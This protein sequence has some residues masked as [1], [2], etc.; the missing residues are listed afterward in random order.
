MAAIAATSVQLS[1]SASG[2]SSGNYKLVEMRGGESQ[3]LDVDNTGAFSGFLI[4]EIPA[5]ST[6][7]YK[8]KET[9]VTEVLSSIE[10]VFA[11]YP[12]PSSQELFLSYSV[13][14]ESLIT[15]AINDLLGVEKISD[16]FVTGI[17][18][19]QHSI[20]CDGLPSGVYQLEVN[21][22]GMNKVFKIVIQE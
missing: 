3:L 5:Y 14:G 22:N 16:A 18:V 11:V 4:A 7:I 12:V 9:I 10:S 6:L 17:K 8:I 19:G 20:A 15:Y 13:L 2:I 1:I 21:C